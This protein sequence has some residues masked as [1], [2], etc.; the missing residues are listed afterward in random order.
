MRLALCALLLF[1]GL[2]QAEPKPPAAKKSTPVPTLDDSLAPL[3]IDPALLD[4]AY[5]RAQVK[6]DVGIAVAAPGVALSVIGSVLIGLAASNPNLLDGGKQA[7]DGIIVCS[8]GIVLGVPGTALWIVGQD[9]MDL[10]IWRKKQLLE[11]GG[12]F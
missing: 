6:R 11:L 1:G 2:A 9:Q 8:L 3:R 12:R 5:R 7:A 4:Q 10:A